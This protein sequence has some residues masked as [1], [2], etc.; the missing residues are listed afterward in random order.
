MAHHTFVNF[1]NLNVAF[2]VGGDHF[3]A[4]PVLP[5]LVCHLMDVLWQLVNGQA[6][7]CVDR[8]ALHRAASSQHVGWP[9]PLVVGRACVEPQI[10]QLIFTTFR[11]CVN[12]HSQAS[13]HC[14]Q[15]VSGVFFLTAPG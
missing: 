15:H 1:R 9:L 4:W 12:R 6:R 14:R 5:L 7:A 3:A 10:V 11:V 2:V 8:L 13:A